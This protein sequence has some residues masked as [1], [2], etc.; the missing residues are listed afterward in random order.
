[1]SRPGDIF[2]LDADGLHDVFYSVDGRQIS[3]RDQVLVAGIYVVAHTNDLRAH[4][5]KLHSQLLAFEQSF[6]F[7]PANADSDFEA[8]EQLYQ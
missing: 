3:I 5:E 6:D 2:R 8:L 1:M 4:L 7:D